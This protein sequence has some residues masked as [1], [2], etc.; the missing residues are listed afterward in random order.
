MLNE[1]ESQGY[2]KDKFVFLSAVTAVV[3]STAKSSCV[4]AVQE[5]SITNLLG[6]GK[7]GLPEAA[8]CSIYQ[9]HCLLPRQGFST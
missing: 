8:S 7:E 9:E 3:A 5:N 4:P 6:E 1:A 2:P